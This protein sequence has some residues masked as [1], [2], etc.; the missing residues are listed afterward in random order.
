LSFLSS[1]TTLLKAALPCGD[2]V[3]CTV[4]AD[5]SSTRFLFYRLGNVC[6]GEGCGEAGYSSGTLLDGLDKVVHIAFNELRRF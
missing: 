2:L 4:C 5:F 1:F 3:F 6:M